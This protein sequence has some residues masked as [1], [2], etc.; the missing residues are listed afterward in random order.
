MICEWPRYTAG[1]SEVK[2]HV[3][4]LQPAPS[5]PLY[6]GR[7]PAGFPSPAAEYADDKL[8][9]HEFLVKNEVATFY[10]TVEGDSMIGAGI[11]PGDVL[12][13][14]S[15]LNAVHGSIV[16]AELD[17]ETTCKRLETRPRVRLLSE[18][19]AYSPVEIR[20]PE[21]LQIWGVVTGLARN[22]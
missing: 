1:M 10:A 18:N 17:G 9:L 2:I 14:N 19:P 11:L 13:V 5:L 7:V 3:P 16:I 21:Q 8:N 22:L 12:V 15:A 6:T 4:D 20:N